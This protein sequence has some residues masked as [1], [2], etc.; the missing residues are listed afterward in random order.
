[1]IDKRELQVLQAA[2]FQFLLS[3]I[4]KLAKQLQF[5]FLLKKSIRSCGCVG[6]QAGQGL[7]VALIYLNLRLK[8]DLHLPSLDESGLQAIVGGVRLLVQ[9]SYQGQLRTAEACYDD[10][11]ASAESFTST[12]ASFPSVVE[13]F[14]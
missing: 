9:R 6:S 5:L 10:A 4:S 12:E 11:L 8:E 2:F 13:S 7:A 3:A 1:M 14:R